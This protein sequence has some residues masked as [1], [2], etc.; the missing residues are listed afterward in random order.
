VFSPY[1]PRC[2]AKVLLGPRRMVGFE[3]VD[4]GHRADFRCFCG[5]LVR[6]VIPS[7]ARPERPDRPLRGAA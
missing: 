5:D 1:C 3:R 2:N 6:T 4:T 7:E